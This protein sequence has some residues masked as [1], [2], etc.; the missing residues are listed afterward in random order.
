[1]NRAHLS[2]D[3]GSRDC[4]N[5]GRNCLESYVAGRTLLWPAGGCPTLWLLLLIAIYL[6][7]AIRCAELGLFDFPQGAPLDHARLA[8]LHRQSRGEVARIALPK[9]CVAG[10]Q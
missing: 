10:L 9:G 4:T 5:E 3:G 1:V 7:V 2:V 6:L 8:C